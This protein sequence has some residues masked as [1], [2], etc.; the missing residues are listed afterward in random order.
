MSEEPRK[1][2]TVTISN[3]GDIEDQV[4]TGLRTLEEL[5]KA[6]VLAS[7]SRLNGNLTETARRLGI[8]RTTLYRMLK[9]WEQK[10]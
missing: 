1:P 9:R 10:P 3:F 6:Y 5:T 8:G 4:L 2:F 7:M